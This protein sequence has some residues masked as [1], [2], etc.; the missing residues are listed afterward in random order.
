MHDKHVHGVGARMHVPERDTAG[1]VDALTESASGWLPGRYCGH[2][3]SPCSF[4]DV[5][6]HD[7][8]LFDD[9]VRTGSTVVKTCQFLRQVRAGR[10]VFAVTHF[11]A[12]EEGRQKL[13]D[14]ALDE[15][16]ALNTLP[17]VLN[18]DEQGRL[19]RKLVVL[20]IEKWL[21][22]NLREIIGLPERPD[23]GFY[24]IDMSS[25]NPRFTRKIWSNDQLPALREERE[26]AR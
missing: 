21:A 2:D 13:A 16:L 6:G 18:R 26:K 11:Y 20:K 19:R 12:S 1:G 7:I 14:S 5:A 23:T 25:K 9:M 10:L 22:R 3:G 8:V 15:I 4:E 24:Q 17:T